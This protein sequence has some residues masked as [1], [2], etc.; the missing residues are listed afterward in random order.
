MPQI[1]GFITLTD[2]NDGVSGYQFTLSMAGQTFVADAS[3]GV[4]DGQ[5][6]TFSSQV[7]AYKGT[8]PMTYAGATTTPGTNQ[9][10]ITNGTQ[11][12]AAAITTSP[13]TPALAG[14]TFSVSAT[15]VI[16]VARNSAISTGF[17]SGAI[18][19]VVVSV[20]LLFDGQTTNVVTQAI[21]FS[22]A[23]GGSAP[24]VF[25]GSTSY[26]LP[27]TSSTVPRTIAL[28]T[29][30]AAATGTTTFT[31]SSTSGLSNNL[32][33]YSTTGIPANTY[34]VSFTSTTVTLSQGSTATIA[35]GST[36][37]FGAAPAI[38][39]SQSP[40]ITTA[41]TNTWSYSLTG[42]SFTPIS[43]AVTSAAASSSTNVTIS[44]APTGFTIAIGQYFRG[45]NVPN[46]TTITAVASQT[47]FT[48][49][50]TPTGSLTTA[51][52]A[53]SISNETYG[54]LSNTVGNQDTLTITPT[55]FQI[56]AGNS[57]SVTYQATRVGSYDTASI[58]KTY[59]GIGAVIVNITSSAAIAFKNGLGSTTLTATLTIG[60]IV[61]A[62][63]TTYQWYKDGSIVSGATSQTLLVNAS[64]IAV[65]TSSQYSCQVS[66]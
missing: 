10:A 3:G 4:S 61:Y 33:V 41:D 55:Q 23:I 43:V 18:Q 52:N 46:N 9:W 64:A 11:S 31:M 6:A 5:L 28:T 39:T 15:G 44:V 7:F 49:S 59:D 47:S 50:N 27:F 37:T 42:V 13:S 8:T 34:V 57:N 38:L 48:I 29:S 56:L 19:S 62:G 32:F 36:F 14:L 58:A 35:S 21:A 40:N 12:G 25:L 45:T 54:L 30:A 24:Y 53:Y 66:Y 60:G 51:A 16:T 22:K 63:T 26:T 20:P 17:P 65:N 2:I 1:A